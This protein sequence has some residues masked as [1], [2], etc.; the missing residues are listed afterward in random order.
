MAYTAAGAD[1]LKALIQS[2]PLNEK[3]RLRDDVLPRARKREWLFKGIG[4]GDGETILLA[5]ELEEYVW[6]AKI[7]YID[8]E[9]Y[10]NRTN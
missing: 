9:K 10:L 5:P 3:L 7:D 6:E 1:K 8:W 4:E 2:I